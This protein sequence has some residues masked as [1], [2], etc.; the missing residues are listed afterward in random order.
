MYT[1]H[2]TY[3]YND[4][5]LYIIIYIYTQ[6]YLRNS[7]CHVPMLWPVVMRTCVRTMVDKQLLRRFRAST[8]WFVVWS[9]LTAHLNAFFFEWMHVFLSRQH[10]IS[11]KLEFP[12]SLLLNS[13]FYYQK[14]ISNVH[15]GARSLAKAHADAVTSIFAATFCVGYNIQT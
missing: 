9:P 8:Q 6:N 5:Y 15:S 14:N 13:N 11:L 3:I 12:I 4:I 1:V 2:H 10:F 7:I